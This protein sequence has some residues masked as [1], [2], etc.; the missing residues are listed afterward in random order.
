MKD[1]APDLRTPV[2]HRTHDETTRDVIGGDRDPQIVTRYELLAR[3]MPSLLARLRPLDRT[4]DG[5][6]S[7]FTTR[8]SQRRRLDTARRVRF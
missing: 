7:Y 3:N 8:D 1:R 5:I 4:S 2:L 6:L